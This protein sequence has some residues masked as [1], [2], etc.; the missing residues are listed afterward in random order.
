MNKGMNK[1]AQEGLSS[2][3][4]ILLVIAVLVLVVVV[5]GFMKGW[6]YIF[7]KIGLLPND[8]DAAIAACTTYSGSD[9]F[10]A[11][12]CELREY[13]FDGEKQYASCGEVYTQAVK[14]LGQD[15]VGF[16]D[17]YVDWCQGTII[18]DFCTEKNLKKGTLVDGVPC[19]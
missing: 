9:S 15:N 11:S 5:L 12:Y 16:E 10:K 3:T 8:L 14:K 2:G 18:T 17:R 7:D 13:R 1:R 19:P 4:L 6:G